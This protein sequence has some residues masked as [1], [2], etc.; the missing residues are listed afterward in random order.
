MQQEDVLELLKSLDSKVWAAIIT[1]SIAMIAALLNFWNQRKAIK[2]QGKQLAILQRDKKIEKIRKKLDDFYNPFDLLLSKVAELYKVFRN[3]LPNDFRT[4]V[5]LVDKDTIFTNKDGTKSKVELSDDKIV[6]LTH[7]INGLEDLEK[8]IL[9]RSSVIDDSRLTK[10][11]KPDSRITD[12]ELLMDPEQPSS[13]PK[14]IGL[15][16]LFIA[17]VHYMNSAFNGDLNKSDL[18][19]IENYVFP[20][21][22]NKIIKENI[23]NL[24]EEIKSISND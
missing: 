6:L 18:A 13:I 23:I 2:L 21:E 10:S 5:Y 9:K 16:T 14:D 24:K 17:H 4:L 7:I 3:G 12:I 19:L 8:H 11:Y 1:A 22:L 15:F 20:R